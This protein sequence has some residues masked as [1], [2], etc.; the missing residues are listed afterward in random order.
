[1][2]RLVGSF[3]QD[4]LKTCSWWCHHFRRF[5]VAISNDN[6]QLKLFFGMA[7]LKKLNIFSRGIELGGGWGIKAFLAWNVSEKFSLEIVYTSS[8]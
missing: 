8:S 1:M 6:I 4:F 3:K 2:Q 5:R 7:P